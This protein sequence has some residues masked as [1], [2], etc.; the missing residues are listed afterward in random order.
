[1]FS[2]RLRTDGS[3][4]DHSESTAAFLD[5]IAG[6][7]WDQV[8]ELI[9]AWVSDLPASARGDVVGRLKDDDYGQ[10]SGA[11]WE[12]YLHQTFLRSGYDITIHPI[13]LGSERQPDFLV[14]DGTEAFYAE[15]KT[16]VGRAANKGESARKARLYDRI[17]KINCPNFFLGIDVNAVGPADISAKPLCRALESWVASLDPDVVIAAG[18]LIDTV[19][20]FQWSV[21]GWEL[22]FQ[23]IPV[24]PEA[25]GKPDH[26]VLGLFGPIRAAWV[27][28]DVTLRAALR[29][30]GSAY[31]ALDHPLVIAVNSFAFSHDN[32]DTMNALYGTEQVA[33]SLNDPDVPP[34]P[35]R[36][37]DGYWLAGTWAHQH[38]AGVLLSRSMAPWRVAEE[39]PTFWQHSQ[40]GG[41]VTPLPHWRVAEAV[42]NQIQ[43][44]DPSAS[45]VELF[46]LPQSWPVGEPFPREATA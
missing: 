9:E 26:R 37:A 39:I 45:I 5:R 3:P 8:R 21:A 34:V 1:M 41:D 11:F 44:R 25:P 22:E 46:G 28:D 13:V 6:S 4:A 36:K 30:K 40:P 10:L 33:L 38:V 23:P 17:N 31:G 7:Y 27:N 42:G 14:S 35:S 12:L 24:K 16:L 19:D 20:R 29:D 15:A 32:F 18:S 2:N 43:F